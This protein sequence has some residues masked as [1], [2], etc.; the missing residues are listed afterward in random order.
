MA[1]VYDLL[2]RVR[3]VSRDRSNGLTAQI[4][5]NRTA[6]WLIPDSFSSN[7]QGRRGGG[8]LRGGRREIG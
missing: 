1:G 4:S 6:L 7:E 3:Y 5:F 8:D 2:G